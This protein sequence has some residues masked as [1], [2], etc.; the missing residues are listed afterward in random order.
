MLLRL[1][2]NIRV[3]LFNCKYS[4]GTETEDDTTAWQLEKDVNQRTRI[5]LKRIQRSCKEPGHNGMIESWLEGQNLVQIYNW[6]QV[7]QHW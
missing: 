6:K 2:R 4:R 7:N 1:T 3:N 5:D